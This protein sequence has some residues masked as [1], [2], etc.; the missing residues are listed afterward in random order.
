[1]WYLT[2]PPFLKNTFILYYT[3]KSC[4][5]K[6][7]PC[8]SHSSACIP[9]EKWCDGKVDCKDG[10]DEKQC[11]GKNKVAMSK[12]HKKILL[13]SILIMMLF[14]RGHSLNKCA[15]WGL[16][17]YI[18]LTGSLSVCGGANERFKHAYSWPSK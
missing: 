1:M 6:T 10:S 7:R 11:S 4:P 13:S 5:E 8:I 12:H 18:W 16:L 14:Y 2:T 17:A 3:G 9:V 15:S